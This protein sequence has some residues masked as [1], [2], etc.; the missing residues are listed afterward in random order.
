MV[1]ICGLA[2]IQAHAVLD[3]G[4]KEL[5][6]RWVKN[7]L[8]WCSGYQQDRQYCRDQAARNIEMTERFLT[9][10]ARQGGWQV[11]CGRCC[12]PDSSMWRLANI[13]QTRNVRVIIL[14]RIRPQ[15]SNKLGE[16]GRGQIIA[17]AMQGS[18]SEGSVGAAS[19]YLLPQLFLSRGPRVF[20]YGPLQIR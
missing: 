4:N 12:S 1:H 8:F 9:E 15:E 6:P 10:E 19:A 7:L 20:A 11:L 5:S 3:S 17:R 2:C 14:A 18:K 13:E 16:S